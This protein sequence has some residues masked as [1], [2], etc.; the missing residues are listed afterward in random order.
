[1][2]VKLTSLGK[3][4]S[5]CWSRAEVETAKT[6]VKKHPSP[7]EEE[8]TFLFSGEFRIAV[9][10]ASEKGMIEHAFLEDLHASIPNLSFE[11][12]RHTKGLIARINVHGRWHEGRVSGADLGIVI[13]RPLVRVRNAGTTVEFHRNHGNGLLAQAKL[14]KQLGLTGKLKWDTLTQRQQDLFPK[15]HEYYSLLLY[16]LQGQT[17]LKPFSWQLC[18]KYSVEQAQEWLQTN[19]FPAE[20]SSTEVLRMLFAR[21]IGTEDPKLIKTIIDPSISDARSIE[22]HIFWPDGGGPPPSLSVYQS[23][24]VQQQIRH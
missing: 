3:L 4:I 10:A 19:V 9:E 14:G 8:I 11:I 20:L 21:A 24:T 1:M 13:L 18:K 15:L 16:R 12:T 2:E 5:D 22:V 17:N 7:S 6:I 23:Q